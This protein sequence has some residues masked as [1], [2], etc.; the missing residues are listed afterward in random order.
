[1]ISLPDNYKL[2]EKY[3][4]PKLHMRKLCSQHLLTLDLNIRTLCSL[5]RAGIRTIGDLVQRSEGE[6]A[7]VWRLG[8]KSMEEIKRA[9][10]FINLRFGMRIE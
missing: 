2:Y 4:E 7:Q 8:S 10:S 6:V 9:L 3:E 1:M 5:E